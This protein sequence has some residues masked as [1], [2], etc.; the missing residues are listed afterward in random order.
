MSTATLVALVFILYPLWGVAL[1]GAVYA[2]WFD[3]KRTLP[4][5]NWRRLL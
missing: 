4:K 1:P 2:L 3:P 5:G